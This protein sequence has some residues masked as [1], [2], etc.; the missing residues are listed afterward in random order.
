MSLGKNGPRP[1]ISES[2]LKNHLENQGYSAAKIRK[3]VD[4]S[5]GDGLVGGLLQANMIEP[6]EHGWIV[7]D[8]TWASAMML[9]KDGE[10]R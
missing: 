7:I 3:A 10:A 8:D 5:N 6:F 2:G 9:S 4:P 1:Y